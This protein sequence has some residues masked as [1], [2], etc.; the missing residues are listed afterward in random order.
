MRKLAVACIC[1]SASHLQA[2]ESHE[3][4][5][6]IRIRCPSSPEFENFVKSI[7]PAGYNSASYE[8]W[9]ASFVSSMTQ[10]ICLVESGKIS[11]SFW[12]A[13]TDDPQCIE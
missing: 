8:E 5:I 12:S 1:L 6:D 2:V 7:P 3:I 9:K 10:L 11:S 4:A 13:K